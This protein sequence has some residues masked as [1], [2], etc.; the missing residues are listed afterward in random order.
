MKP[1]SDSPGKLL[2][3]GRSEGNNICLTISLWEVKDISTLLLRG[4]PFADPILMWV[5][6]SSY[7]GLGSPRSAYVPFPGGHSS[8]S[9]KIM[10]AG[11]PFPHPIPLSINNALTV[12]ISGSKLMPNTEGYLFLSQECSFVYNNVCY[13]F[14]TEFPG[15]FRQRAFKWSSQT[16]CCTGILISYFITD[17][18]FPLKYT[19]SSGIIMPCILVECE[20]N[21]SGWSFLHFP[22]DKKMNV[23]FLPSWNFKQ[24]MKVE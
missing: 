24:R 23:P 17:L 18:Y 8:T 9:P 4:P 14:F 15:V 12:P 21:S 2:S 3:I 13:L 11:L 22:D 7:F 16:C 5:S 20:W 1:R 19:V 10:K 6:Q